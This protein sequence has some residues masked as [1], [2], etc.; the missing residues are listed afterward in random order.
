MKKYKIVVRATFAERVLKAFPK[1]RKYMQRTFYYKAHS[2]EHVLAKLE[3][4]RGIAEGHGSTNTWI[5]H[6]VSVEEILEAQR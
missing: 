6:I 3:Q 1:K 5:W 4:N 2:K